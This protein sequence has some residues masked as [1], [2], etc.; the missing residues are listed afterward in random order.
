[1]LHLG[2]LG[3]AIGSSPVLHMGLQHLPDV[4]PPLAQRLGITLDDKV[5]VVAIG[6]RDGPRAAPPA[7]QRRP[8]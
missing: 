2:N 3:K 4:L 8:R 6:P 5:V 7:D 1:V